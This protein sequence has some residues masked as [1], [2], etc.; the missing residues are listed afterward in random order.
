[1]RSRSAAAQAA[2]SARVANY[3]GPAQ[4]ARGALARRAL[5]HPDYFSSLVRTADRLLAALLEYPIIVREALQGG[6]PVI[7]G[8]GRVACS[9]CRATVALAPIVTHKCSERQ[10]VKLEVRVLFLLPMRLRCVCMLHACPLA[11]GAAPCMAHCT[12][13]PWDP[14]EL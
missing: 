1:M 12:Q 8:S 7:S 13:H 2:E 11:H 14:R 6:Y 5:R 9:R 10:G 3:E 4:A